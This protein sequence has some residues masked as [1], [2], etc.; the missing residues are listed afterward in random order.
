MDQHMGVERGDHL[1]DPVAVGGLDA[2]ELGAAEP[3]AWRVD[4]DA[5]QRPHPRL[6]FQQ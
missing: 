6:A 2:M 4:V 3:P 5:A 1:H